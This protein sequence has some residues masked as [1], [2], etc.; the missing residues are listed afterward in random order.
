MNLRRIERYLTIIGE[1]GADPVIV[2]NKSDLC[3][4]IQT[5]VERVRSIAPTIPVH[6]TRAREQ[7]GLDA[8]N[9]YGAQ[10]STLAFIGSSGVGKS[11]LL[12]ALF[13]ENKMQVADPQADTG[14]GMHTTTHR[15]L[16]ILQDGRIV[17]DNPG[18]RAIHLYDSEDG[19]ERAFQDIR[20]LARH[21]RFR[22][23]RHRQEPDCAVKQSVENGTLDQNR[24]ESYLKLKQE[25]SSRE[26]Y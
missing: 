13:G 26:P 9:Q 22:N 4:D 11:T 2:L 21:C 5:Q 3:E 7:E 17:I 8:L 6:V 14:R 10:G 23:C 18:M 1:S 12:N 24:Y 25:L 19:L 15:Q 20:D 16:F